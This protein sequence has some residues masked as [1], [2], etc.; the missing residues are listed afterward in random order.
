VQPH[1]TAADGAFAIAG[2]GDESHTLWIQ[3]AD[4]W[5]DFPL[6]I[7]EDVRPGGA[8]LELI[9]DDREARAARIAVRVLSPDRQPVAGAELQVWHED[10]QLWRSFVAHGSD[11]R[12]EVEDAPPGTSELELR[13]AEFP[14]LSLGRRELLAGETLDLGDVVLDQPGRLRAR[15][16]GVD[17]GTLRNVRAL[18]TNA[19]NRESGVARV[20]EGGELRSGPLAAGRHTLVL[21]GDFVRMVKLDVEVHA[22]VETEL[23][24]ALERCEMRRVVFEL[25]P[26]AVRPRWLAC[27]ARDGGPTEPWFDSVGANGPLE[28]RVSLPRGVYRLVAVGE[29]GWGGE[30]ELAID[31]SSEALVVGLT[32]R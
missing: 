23:D 32:K 4:G 27:G 28:A 18:L 29:G 16:R 24:L 20:E 21:R 15:L 17:A 22:G 26:G 10:L 11:G 8:P 5:R 9:V 19:S 12:I 14:W 25:P 6:S 1:T 2:I 3:R 13:H 30:W 7:V 31:G